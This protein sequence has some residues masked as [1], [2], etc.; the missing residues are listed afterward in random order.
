MHYEWQD[1]A[2][3]KVQELPDW[4]WVKGQKQGGSYTGSEGWL[5]WKSTKEGKMNARVRK[6][7]RREGV[8]SKKMISDVLCGRQ[9]NYNFMAKLK[10]RWKG[11]LDTQTVCISK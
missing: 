3:I 8:A 10:F 4:Q 9:N 6:M 1:G 11:N 7:N 2:E 5:L